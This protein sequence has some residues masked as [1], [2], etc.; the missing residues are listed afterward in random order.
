MEPVA[1]PQSQAE[2]FERVQALIQS[3]IH[4]IPDHSP[5]R[6]T[7]GPGI[8]LEHQL[9]LTTNSADLPDSVGWELKWCSPRTSLVTLF[10][11]EADGPSRIMRYM[12][13]KYGKKDSQGR[14]SFRH[15]V[16]GR[17]DR[18]RVYYE[19]G[20]L[21]VR[22]R[23]KNG[24][25]PYW[26]EDSILAAAGAKL[27]RLLLVNGERKGR[28]VRFV[29]ADAFDTFSLTDFIYEIERGEIAIDFDCRE[30]SPGSAGLRN[31]G[32]KFRM[33]PDSLCRLYMN[34]RRIR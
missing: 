16:R 19:S 1:P 14:L 17:S 11:K 26:L 34:K 21:V 29:R 7:G 18:F 9:G 33:A 15:T 31:H 8:Y 32:T 20:Q 23:G 25:V 12:V 5:Y 4:E 3:G 24:P 30:S 10:H 28:E 6:G 27:R 13:R 2:L 22:P